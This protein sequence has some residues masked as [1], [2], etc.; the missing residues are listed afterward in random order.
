MDCRNGTLHNHKLH[1]QVQVLA[2][3]ARAQE[4]VNAAK[5]EA[6]KTVVEANG[7]RDAAVADAAAILAK[8][9][10]EAEAQR[11]KLSAYAVPGAE[12]FVQIEVA[13]SMAEAFKG[14]QGYLPGD[15][16]IN[17]LSDSFLKSVRGMMAPVPPSRLI[18]TK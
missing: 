7:R 12:A 16:Q 10:A 1:K 9:Q 13:Q 5:A 8:G 14:I 4:Q 3:E 2:S 18:E 11:L 17:L 15:M 6:E